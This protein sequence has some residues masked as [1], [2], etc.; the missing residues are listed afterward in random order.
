MALSATATTIY[1]AGRFSGF[2]S[3]STSGNTPW[4]ENLYPN[5]PSSTGMSGL[6]HGNG[7][8]VAV[9]PNATGTSDDGETWTF[10]H[11]PAGL[12][13]VAFGA[14]RFV[15]AG[16]G[17]VAALSF[18]GRSWQTRLLGTA[19]IRDVTHGN[20]QFVAA[21]ALGKAYTSPDGLTWTERS[22]GI[23]T[24]IESLAYGNGLFAGVGAA[25]QVSSTNGI[26]WQNSALA[27]NLAFHDIHFA[28]GLWIRVGENSRAGIIQSS[29]NGTAWTT[30]LQLSGNSQLYGVTRIEGLWVAVGEPPGNDQGAGVYTSTNGLVWSATSAHRNGPLRAIAGGNGIAVAVGDAQVLL[31]AE[32]PDTRSPLLTLQPAD[33]EVPQGGTLTLSVQASGTVPLTLQWYRDGSPLAE[34]GRI[35]GASSATLRITGILQSD[36]GSYSVVVAN[37]SGSRSSRTAR[38]TVTDSG[39]S[40]ATTFAQWRQGFPLPAGQMEPADDPDGDRLANVVE[41]A[42]GSDPTRADSGQLPQVVIADDSGI[43]YPAV[44]FLRDPRLRGVSIEVQ[45]AS[46]IEFATPLATREIAPAEVLEGG[47]E[48]VTIRAD[49][50]ASALP[51]VFF[52]ST[53]RLPQ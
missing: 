29:T 24:T 23:S 50:P 21:G 28:E 18:D 12:V 48:R 33:A 51:R 20:G 53:V 49:I 9:G 11:L 36:A 5:P 34:G 17:G 39:G 22:T 14:G 43:A 41:Y 46:D 52:R 38:I 8:F 37:E 26:V 27:R 42:F 7:R 19:N 1:A 10:H 31:K 4:R 40:G 6:V 15:A 30:R 16:D 3:T 13:R 35:T 44:S 47:L 32:Y 25:S 2:L 45:A